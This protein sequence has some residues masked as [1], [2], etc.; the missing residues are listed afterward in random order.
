MASTSKIFV[1]PGVYTSEKDL[2]FVTRQVGVTTLGLLGETPKGPAFEPVFISNYDDFT[3]YFGSL[4]PS[5]FKETGY[6]KYE[7]NYIAKSFLT[8]TNQLYVSR[9]LGH[10]GYDAGPAWSITLDS[11]ADS[12]TAAPISTGSTGGLLFSA[13]TAG[14]PVTMTFDNA[15][16]Q[17]LYDNGL[18]SNQFT[19]I[20]LLST[21]QT[22]SI[23]SP[24][25]IKTGSTFSGATFD[26]TV[27]AIGSGGTGFVTGTTT[28]TVVTYTANTYTEIEDS[29]IATIRSRGEYDGDEQLIFDVTG[30][31]DTEMSDTTAI[32]TD[33][34]ATFSITGT[35]S[36]G[37]SFS[38]SVSLDNTKKNYIESVLGLSPEDG[39]SEL[40]VGDLYTNCLIDL[41]NAG[42]VRGLKTTFVRIP[43]N[44]EN[45][46]SQWSWAET[47]WVLSQLQGTNLKRLFKFRTISDGDN[48]NKDVKF[49]IINIKPD[50][51]TFDLL[52]RNY[53]DTD[54]NPS[55]VEKF[56][57]LS[58][59]PTSNGYIAR[60][61]G[62]LDGEFPLKSK[63]IMVVMGDENTETSF[64]AGFEGVTTRDYVGENRTAL[65]PQIE[66]NTEYQTGISNGKLRRTY[67]GLSSRIGVDQDFFTFKGSSQTIPN[68]N[69]DYWTGKTDGFHLDVNANGAEIDLSDGSVYVPELQVGVSAFTT[70]N[71]L[72]NGPYERLSARKFTFTSY[73]GFDGWDIYRESRTNGDSYTINGTDGKQGEIVNTFYPS[74]TSEG[75]I[76][77]TSDYY[78]FL[79]GI[80]TYNNPESVNINVFASPGLDII[81][82]TSLVENAIDMIETD[83][84]DSLY[85]I[86]TPDVDSGGEP[87][88]ADD[89]VAFV[90][91]SAI[92]SNY[93][94][95]YWPWLQMNDTEN[96][97]Y[98]WLPPTLEVVRNIALTDNVAFPWF[99]S[100]GLNRGTTNA[101][102]ARVKL[103]LDQRDTLYEGR[104]NPMATFSDVGVVIWGNKTLQEKET[105]LNRI[106]V[107]RLLLQ[108]RKLISAVS[109]RLLFEQNDEV[110]RNQ[111][112][113][114]VNPILDNIRKERGLTDFRVVLDDTPE[115]IDRNEL[116]GRIFIKPT[117]TLEYI[118][119]EFNI[120]N[121]GANF[122]DI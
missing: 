120:T 18:I 75:D 98:V 106:N 88:S 13:S 30:S 53:Y 19:G 32:M 2:T 6:H 5:K 93:S 58:M 41:N 82:Q 34:L 109:I 64:P 65:P 56:S 25:Y 113:S 78:S 112:L 38:Y 63:Y 122:D 101:I 20:G 55:I 26:L 54:E 3:S 92:D 43:T 73:G 72:E 95:T 31:T 40:F 52:V 90:E 42:K 9:V 48:A 22:I 79:N 8:Q 33:P 115:S 87:M 96:N 12:S 76:G 11:A 17:S 108:A 99:A 77:N 81:D 67:L 119:I 44:L 66:Y 94:A 84:A 27:T 118:N 71:S 1:S 47:P 117:R 57:R 68:Y 45:Y 97:Q 14:T 21:G 16:L 104:I 121:T 23:T 24:Q 80:Y 60:R 46:Q 69:G 105:A 37:N 91:D 35:S 70:D 111:F 51:G 114:L 103:T 50:S 29:V 49:S 116:N 4:N 10:S 110:V 107:R 102:K 61:I 39:N 7:L 36:A 28:G 89:A 62:T 15:L 86:T 100:A 83:R 74:T 85:I 59:D